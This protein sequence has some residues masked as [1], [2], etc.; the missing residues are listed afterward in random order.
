[1]KSKNLGKSISK[2]TSEVEVINITKNGLWLLVQK[3]EYF[4][5]YTEYPWFSEAKIS[6]IHNVNLENFNRLH[7]PSLDI[8]L[9]IDCLDNL[10]KYP[11]VYHN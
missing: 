3:K 9:E 6:D 5:P 8:D 7:W 11:L 4:L 1:M 10:E 2:T